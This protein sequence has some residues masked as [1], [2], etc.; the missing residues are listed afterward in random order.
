L[1]IKG[2]SWKDYHFVNLTIT[3][4]NQVNQT[5][6]PDTSINNHISNTFYYLTMSNSRKSNTFG[7]SQEGTVRREKL[8][9]RI[10][11]SSGIFGGAVFNNDILKH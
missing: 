10:K 9:V 8:F 6:A 5:M 2:S 1:G 11:T 4:N 3:D 7:T